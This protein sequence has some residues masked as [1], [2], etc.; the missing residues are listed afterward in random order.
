MSYKTAKLSKSKNSQTFSL[1][2]FTTISM[3][4]QFIKISFCCAWVSSKVD[5]VSVVNFITRLLLSNIFFA[6]ILIPGA[7]G[8]FGNLFISIFGDL[9]Y[10]RLPKGGLA[11]AFQSSW[12]IESGTYIRP[13]IFEINSISNRHCQGEH[14]N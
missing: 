9:P 2:V 1:Y 11:W 14:S 3:A 13:T 6:G 4:A 8:N 10:S 7:V 12:Q 5:L